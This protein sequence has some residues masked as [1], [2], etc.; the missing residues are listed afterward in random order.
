MKKQ[1]HKN[2]KFSSFLLHE[3]RNLSFVGNLLAH[4]D[5]AQSFKIAFRPRMILIAAPTL[6]AMSGSQIRDEME[7]HQPIEMAQAG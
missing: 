1:I 3:L 7:I 2:C 6:I 4:S 5:F